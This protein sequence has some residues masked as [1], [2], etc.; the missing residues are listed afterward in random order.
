MVAIDTTTLLQMFI[1]WKHARHNDWYYRK[2]EETEDM[3]PI[4]KEPHSSWRE[5]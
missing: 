3:V 5:S 4:L 2:H 1:E